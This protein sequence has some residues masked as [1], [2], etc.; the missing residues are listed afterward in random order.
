MVAALD[1]RNSGPGRD[2]L[3]SPLH[4]SII[5]SMTSAEI[6]E[7]SIGTTIFRRFLHEPASQ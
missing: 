7:T 5:I 1:H 3:S 4:K 6:D 2:T